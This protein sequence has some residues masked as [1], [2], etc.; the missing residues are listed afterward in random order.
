MQEKESIMG[1]VLRS[2][3]STRGMTGPGGIEAPPFID[4]HHEYKL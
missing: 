3:F 4:S 2:A 1:M